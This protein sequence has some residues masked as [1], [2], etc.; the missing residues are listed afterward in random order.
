MEIGRS[1]KQSTP[2]VK[3]YKETMENQDNQRIAPRHP[4][5]AAVTCRPFHSNGTTTAA[6]AVMRN[7]S[8]SGS[9]IESVHAF[10]IG[11]VI[12][13]RMVQYPS[14]LESRDWDDRPRSTCLAAIKWR[15]RLADGRDGAY[16][17]GLKYLE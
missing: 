9:Y 6:D 12:Q 10:K 15:R 7:F 3:A 5:E 2:Q 1:L 11:A 14:P 13:L 8:K 17:F 4:T 16:G